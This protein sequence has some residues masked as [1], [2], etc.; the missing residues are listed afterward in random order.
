MKKLILAAL[1]PA[2]VGLAVPAL[3]QHAPPPPGLWTLSKAP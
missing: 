2:T 1:I 3:A